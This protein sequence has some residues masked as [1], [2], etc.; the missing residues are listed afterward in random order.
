M[1]KIWTHLFRSRPKLFWFDLI[2]SEKRNCPLFRRN[3]TVSL[4]QNPKILKPSLP[5]VNSSTLSIPFNCAS[6]PISSQGVYYEKWR[7]SYPFRTGFRVHRLTTT[8]ELRDTE[9]FKVLTNYIMKYNCSI[10]KKEI[11]REIQ[12]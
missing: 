10:V 11:L 1:S 8:P 2:R 9:E 5:G 12:S 6:N 7:L 3:S 4:F